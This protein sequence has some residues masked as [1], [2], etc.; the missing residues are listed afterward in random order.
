MI[1]VICV[2]PISA[3]LFFVHHCLRNG[4]LISNALRGLFL[5]ICLI[6]SLIMDVVASCFGPTLEGAEH[7]AS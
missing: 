5:S 3:L 4:S 6:N 1:L 2:S 7:N